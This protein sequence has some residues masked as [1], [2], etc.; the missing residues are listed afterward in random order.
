MKANWLKV[1]SQVSKLTSKNYQRRQSR[2]GKRSIIRPSERP[3][4]RYLDNCR[5]KENP[6]KLES[7]QK[8][9]D[10][11]ND[12]IKIID[13]K[14]K[15]TD[16]VN[17]E[18]LQKSLQEEKHPEVEIIK[19]IKKPNPTQITSANKERKEREIVIPGIR[20]TGN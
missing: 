16:L 20:Y 12:I 17:N 14:N 4:G 18:S 6:K 8:Q 15:D 5:S 9:S 1:T 19:S 11:I 10:Y 7:V 2:I 13:S 3:S